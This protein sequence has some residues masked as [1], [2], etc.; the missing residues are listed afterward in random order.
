SCRMSCA[1]QRLCDA[2]GLEAILTD[3]AE[4][5]AHAR[6]AEAPLRLVGVRSR[7]VP[8]AQRIAARLREILG[9]DVPVGAVD[10]TLYRDDFGQRDAWPE[11]RETDIPF[12][13]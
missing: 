9:E 7:G 6:C 1:Q 13:V 12:P 3:L 8:L 4:A 10:I 2:K 11:L 5:I